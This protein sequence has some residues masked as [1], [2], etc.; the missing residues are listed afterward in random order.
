MPPRAGRSAVNHW[1]E[2]KCAK[3]FWS[4]QETTPYRQLHRD[5]LAWAAPQAGERWLDL[6]CGSG[7]L[8]RGL[9]EASRGQVAE[10]VGLDCAA[11]NAEAYEH[12]RRVLHPA[13]GSR[14]RF[15]T[16]DFSHGLEIF[17]DASF[18]H[19]ISGLSISYAQ[20]WSEAEERWT[21]QAYDRLL[22]EVWRVLKPGGRF[23]FS[24]NVPEP[25]WW[26]VALASLGDAFRSDKPLRF[27]RRSWRMLRYGRWLKAEARRGRFHYLPAEVVQRKLEAA[28][29][30]A[31]EHRRSYAGQAYVFRAIKGKDE[32]SVSGD[33]S[34]S[35]A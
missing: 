33:R 30:T 11:V 8:S 3:A 14:L 12:L 19:A 32:R 6:G 16:H 29:F 20:S 35:S 18:D 2:A 7:A 9:W 27:L 15:L 26:R 1:L 28:G 13:P 25:K 5:T 17:P 22:R 10:I 21:T 34:V 31:V 24:V 23:V 4:Q